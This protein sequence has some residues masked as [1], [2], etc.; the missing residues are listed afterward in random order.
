MCLVLK[1]EKSEIKILAW[2]LM[3][4]LLLHVHMREDRMESEKMLQG[5]FYTSLSPIRE[6]RTLMV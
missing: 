4:V 3:R 5:A 6:G 1:A 2:C